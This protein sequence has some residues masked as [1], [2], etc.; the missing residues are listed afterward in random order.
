MM[1]VATKRFYRRNVLK[2]EVFKLVMVLGNITAF[3]GIMPPR[4]PQNGT[5]FTRIGYKYYITMAYYNLP[6]L[7]AL[8][9]DYLC[10]KLLS[11]LYR[12]WSTL[13]RGDS[14]RFV[15]RLLQAAF[16]ILFRT[17]QRK[18]CV[19]R[20]LFGLF[21]GV[22][23]H[24]SRSFAINTCKSLLLFHIPYRHCKVVF[25]L[26][27]RGNTDCYHYTYTGP[28]LGLGLLKDAAKECWLIVTTPIFKRY[29]HDCAANEEA[30][31]FI[32]YK[33]ESSQRRNIVDMIRSVSAPASVG[34]A[35]R[36]RLRLRR[37]VKHI[38]REHVSRLATAEKLHSND[39]NRTTNQSRLSNEFLIDLTSTLITRPRLWRKLKHGKNDLE[40]VDRNT[41]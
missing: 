37:T 13:N 14:Y 40:D 19:L 3:S 7:L 9:L 36:S 1:T 29:E 41:I 24:S 21:T 34:S 39:I 27:G 32:D 4:C 6:R 12:C 20:T 18:Q 31:E 5:K 30:H 26:R 28:M 38:I 10:R 17:P 23:T 25:D 8:V 15:G 16:F 33:Q 22:G 2:C 35:D 11:P